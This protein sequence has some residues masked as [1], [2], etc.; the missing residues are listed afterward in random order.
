MIMGLLPYRLIGL[1][2]ISVEPLDAQV[3]SGS[4]TSDVA[5]TSGVVVPPVPLECGLTPAILEGERG[6]RGNDFH[7]GC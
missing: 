7:Y 2:A 3:L 4:V 6:R 5:S 1:S